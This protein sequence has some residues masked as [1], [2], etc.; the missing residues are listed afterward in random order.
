MEKSAAV[1]GAT[2]FLDCPHLS[3]NGSRSRETSGQRPKRP[4]SHEFGYREKRTKL[5]AA[6]IDLRGE[7]RGKSQ[8]DHV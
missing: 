1:V 4:N 7:P 8:Y 6:S 2:S 5:V 3:L